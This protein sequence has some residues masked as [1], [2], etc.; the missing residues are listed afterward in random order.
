MSDSLIAAAKCN[1]VNLRILCS[2]NRGALSGHTEEYYPVSLLPQRLVAGTTGAPTV[3]LAFV[4]VDH[5]AG[6]AAASKNHYVPVAVTPTHALAE[7]VRFSP[8]GAPHCATDLTALPPSSPSSQSRSPTAPDAASVPSECVLSPPPPRD[9]AAATST[10]TQPSSPHTLP[11]STGTS[12]YGSQTSPSQCSGTLRDSQAAPVSTTRRDCCEVWTKS[13]T[14]G[15]VSAYLDGCA[16]GWRDMKSFA[17]IPTAGQSLWP[18]SSG[19]K[20]NGCFV[21]PPPFGYDLC[22]SL[23]RL[24]LAVEQVAM[25]RPG[26]FTGGNLTRA[27]C[28]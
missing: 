17:R 15:D 28:Q 4:N 11:P 2:S 26:I 6:H 1:N 19:R 23:R 22:R 10:V 9:P 13:V 16:S 25:R 27:S 3:T 21:R 7:D 20:R 24:R 14:E 18:S 8:Q 12:S 5:P